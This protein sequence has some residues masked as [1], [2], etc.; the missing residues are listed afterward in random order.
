MSGQQLA[1]ATAALGHSVPR[2]V[3]A[4]LESGRR[5]TLSVPELLVLAEALNVPPL[6]LVF[7]LGRQSAMEVLPGVDADPWAAAR[8]FAGENV[9]PGAPFAADERWEQAAAVVALFRDHHAAMRKRSQ[10][11]W[12]ANLAFRQMENATDDTERARIESQRREAEDRVR[13]AEGALSGIRS[14]MRKQGLTPPEL[15]AEL[16]H[17]DTHPL[18]RAVERH[19]STPPRPWGAG[20][21]DQAR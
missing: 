16:E 20:G 9:L 11:N 5:E 21:E 17:V 12:Q 15:P 1:D 18:T 3:I 19:Y 2:S 7:P 13:Q 14:D 6:L 4:N 10:A 8:W